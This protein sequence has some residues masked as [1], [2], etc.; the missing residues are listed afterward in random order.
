MPHTKSQA[1]E[2][3]MDGLIAIVNK[4]VD[5]GHSWP[6]SHINALVYACQKDPQN[7]YA[8][9]TLKRL[10]ELHSQQSYLVCE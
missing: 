4:R 5:S 9:G 2:T 8:A 3:L 1:G 7:A 6:C 10:T